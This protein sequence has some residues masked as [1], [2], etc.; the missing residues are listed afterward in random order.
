MVTGCKDL[1]ASRLAAANPCY[2]AGSPDV[3][4]PRARGG[5]KQKWPRDCVRPRPAIRREAL[6]VAEDKELARDASHGQDVSIIRET[7]QLLV[8]PLIFHC[9]SSVP[10]RCTPKTART[11]CEDQIGP[12]PRRWAS[13]PAVS[14]L[15]LTPA[16]WP[17]CRYAPASGSRGELSSCWRDDARARVQTPRQ[18]IVSFAAP[19]SCRNGC[20]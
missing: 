13:R 6:P 12:T 17:S 14:G 20:G 7:G 2:A 16:N 8:A 3:Q 15:T 9:A 18:N 1:A 4:Q 5:S 10:E 11:H 19:L